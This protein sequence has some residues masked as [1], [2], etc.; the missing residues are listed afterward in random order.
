MH[1]VLGLDMEL[2]NIGFGLNNFQKWRY[3][4]RHHDVIVTLKNLHRP[5]ISSNDYLQYL[6]SL[7]ATSIILFKYKRRKIGQNRQKIITIYVCM[8]V[9]MYLSPNIE[10]SI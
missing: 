4:W 6:W 5:R 2:K 3:W 1:Y 10:I 7:K 8:Y 9:C